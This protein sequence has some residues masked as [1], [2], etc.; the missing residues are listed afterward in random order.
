MLLLDE[1]KY[2]RDIGDKIDDIVV[3]IFES[4][5]ISQLKTIIM[6]L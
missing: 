4:I 3:Y 6:K 5:Y 1:I 2:Y